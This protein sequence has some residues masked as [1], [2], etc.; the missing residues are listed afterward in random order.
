MVS[1]NNDAENDCSSCV[2]D[3]F[4][5][6]KIHNRSFK[7]KVFRFLYDRKYALFGRNE[8]IDCCSLLLI[9]ELAQLRSLAN[10]I[11]KVRDSQ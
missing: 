7:N 3:V 6:E 9:K 8:K 4:P 1:S 5:C 2:I 11:I 10:F